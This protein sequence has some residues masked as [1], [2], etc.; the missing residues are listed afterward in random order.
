MHRLGT[1]AAVCAVVIIANGTVA[2]TVDNAIDRAVPF[3]AEPNSLADPYDDIFA[4]SMSPAIAGQLSQWKPGD[5]SK[6]PGWNVDA[7]VVV[8]DVTAGFLPTSSVLAF[9]MFTETHENEGALVDFAP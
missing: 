8:A 9:A 4:G 2:A 6:A 7:A 1:W 5:K 3:S